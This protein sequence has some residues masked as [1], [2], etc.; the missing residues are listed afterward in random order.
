M[1]SPSSSAMRGRA[2][3]GRAPC[4]ARGGSRSPAPRSC[5]SSRA[6]RD[7]PRRPPRASACAPR[8]AGV[9]RRGR[10]R[11]EL[12]AVLEDGRLPGVHRAAPGSRATPRRTARAAPRSIAARP[13]A[14]SIQPPRLAPFDQ[15]HSRYFRARSPRR[16]ACGASRAATARRSGHR[17]CIRGCAGPRSRATRRSARPG[18]S[19][20]RRAAAD[21][22]AAAPRRSA[23]RGRAPDAVRRRRILTAYALP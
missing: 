11:V 7:T 4:A 19:T 18:A 21:R 20:C 15:N 17:G 3:P 5:R 10:D 1:I 2:C 16:G 14:G 23:R 12:H 9:P 8:R 13:S 22:R 6:A